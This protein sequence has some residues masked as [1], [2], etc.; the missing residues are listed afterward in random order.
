L[1]ERG[2]FNENCAWFICPLL[3][4][5]G[6]IRG[7]RENHEARDL[8]RDYRSPQTDEVR[9]H[10]AWLR[11][12]PPFDLTLSLHEDWE[13]KGF[14]L[15]EFNP[16]Q[17]PSLAK[18]IIEAVAMVCTINLSKTIDGHPASAGIVKPASDPAKRERWSESMYLRTHH[19]RL[20]YTLETPSTRLLR[21]RI[22]SHM[23]AV[24]T[25]IGCFLHRSPPKFSRIVESGAGCA[26]WLRYEQKNRNSHE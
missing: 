26:P 1:V 22:A 3:N 6:L 9:A 8:N 25:A 7:T 21:Q 18:S 23:T 11:R 16:D 19:S 24:T 13:S 12:Q 20:C 4:P 2:F 10:V 17:S 5:C 14:Y 15:Y